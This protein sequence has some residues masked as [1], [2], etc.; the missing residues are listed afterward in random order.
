MKRCCFGILF[1]LVALVPVA[2]AQTFPTPGQPINIIVPYPPGGGTDTSARMMA[3]GLQDQLHTTVQVI[4]RPGA[5]SQVGMTELVRS[6]PDGMTLGYAVLPAVLTSYL[7]PR[8]QAIYT[9]KSFQPVATHYIATM[10]LAVRSD[11]PYKTLKDLVDAAKAAPGKVAVSD[12]GL[13]GTPHLTT[14]MVGAAGGVEFNSVHF[15][16]GPPSVTALLGGQVQVLA[17]GI[18]DVLP[19]MR[20]GQFRVLGVAAEQPD[21]LLPDVPTMRSQGF[22]VVSAAIGGIVAPAGT[23]AATVTTITNAVKTVLE[24]PEHAQKLAA[25]G[26]APYYNGPAAFAKLWEETETRIK[27][28][29][30]QLQKR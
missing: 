3:A 15:A 29:L 10:T 12:S 13:L 19:Y 9:R 1:C 28:I 20:S 5:A 21:P 26:S 24:D 7:D 22:D 4:N 8:R 16:G 25:F 30:L 23:P 27:P 17:G 18:S 11:A 2:S 14:L 6:K